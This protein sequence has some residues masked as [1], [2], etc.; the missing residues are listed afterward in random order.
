VFVISADG[1]ELWRSKV[2]RE[3][4]TLPFDV[5][6][7]NVKTLELRVEDGGNG[8]SSDWGVWLDPLLTR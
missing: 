3:G 7:Q 1:K 5:E 6:V 4:E 8:N 2:V